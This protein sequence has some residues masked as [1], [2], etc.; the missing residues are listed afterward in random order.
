MTFRITQISDTHLSAERSFFVDNF[1]RVAAH[2]A[3]DP[4]DLVV[5]TGDMTLDGVQR[6]SDL[7]DA[8]QLHD[9]AFGAPCRF[10]PGNHDLGEAQDAPP[11][12]GCVPISAERRARYIRHFGEDFW[13]LDVPGWRLVALNAQLLGSDLDDAAVQ[14]DFLR[15]AIDT[16]RRVALF[17]H[18]PLFHESP[19]ENVVAGRFINPAPRRALLDVLASHPPALVCS[20]HVHQ[21]LSKEMHGTQHVWAPST[22][23]ILPDRR[24]PRYGLK[25]TGYVEHRLEANGAHASRLVTVPGLPTF[26]IDDFP[27]AYGAAD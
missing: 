2:I 27:S 1:T 19:D 5:N 6:E 10:I 12:P 21:F 18:K 24:Q 17:I 3:A 4:P 7:A 25:Q 23:F 8:R 16:E 14:V 11:H 22:G 15:G 20:G 26:N 9:D 13:C